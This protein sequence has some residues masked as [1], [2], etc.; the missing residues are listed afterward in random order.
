MIIVYIY[1]ASGPLVFWSL[2]L[3]WDCHLKAFKFYWTYF[4]WLLSFE[5]YKSLGLP[6]AVAPLTALCLFGACYP[7]HH[8]KMVSLVVMTECHILNF[9]PTIRHYKKNVNKIT[10]SVEIHVE[11]YT[12]LIIWIITLAKLYYF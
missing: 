8:V 2:L 7:L 9:I 3:C 10:L 4:V 12:N 5:I 11:Y 6:V 1:S